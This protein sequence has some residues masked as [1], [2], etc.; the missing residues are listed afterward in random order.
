MLYA[1]AAPGT[2]ASPTASVTDR[3]TDRATDSAARRA[4]AR[5][6]ATTLVGEPDFRSENLDFIIP[7]GCAG[8]RVQGG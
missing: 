2:N 6:R 3:A 8:L 5:A 1:S 7:P 4:A